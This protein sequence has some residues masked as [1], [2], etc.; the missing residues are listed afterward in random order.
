M[1]EED[2]KAGTPETGGE[3]T[4]AP[5]GD[6]GTGGSLM[7][8]GLNDKPLETKPADDA[9]EG[10]E[11]KPDE[12]AS[13]VPESPDGYE[14]K[15]DEA[16][17]VDTALLDAFQKTAHEVGLTREQAQKLAEMYADKVSNGAENFHQAQ[18]D[19]VLTE[20][21]EW[22]KEITADRDFVKNKAH[23]QKALRQ[24]GSPELYKALDDTKF[25]SF[26]PLFKFVAAVGRELSEP[27]VHGQGANNGAKSAAQVIYPNHP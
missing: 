4:A 21:K 9:G 26:P 11:Q 10:G 15:F 24:F 16:V 1:G 18:I 6:A 12:A 7:T 8:D 2:N 14:L 20:E 23:A 19:K 5:G 17:E 27:G 13:G 3:G 22:L 25:G